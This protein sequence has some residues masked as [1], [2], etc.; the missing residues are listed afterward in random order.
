MRRLIPA[1]LV[2]LALAPAARAE[3]LS[4]LIEEQARGTLGATLPEAAEF[5]IMLST[6]GVEDAV[7][8]SAYWMD[9]A[10]GQFI[11]NAVGAD[12][13]VHRVRGL[14]TVML[15]VP[16]P[17]RRLMPGDI[18]ADNDLSVVR[19]PQGRLG[20]FTV[21]QRDEL[22]G[23]QVRRMLAEGRPVMVQSIMQPLVIDR[24]DLITIHYAD[25]PLKL[26]APGRALG[27]AH[28][29]QEVRIVNLA[30]NTSLAGI[31]ASEGIVEVYR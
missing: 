12:G 29:G 18:V 16:I 26:T 31:A 8:L 23:M 6:A 22:V 19:L 14:A 3:S 4:V 15:Q 28:R 24:G 5:D 1:L 2:A 9:P 20:A 11:A 7:M 30:S 13:A 25:G 10:T 27:D 21:T 17:T